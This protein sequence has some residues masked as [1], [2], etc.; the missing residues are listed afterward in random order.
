MDF[1]RILLLWVTNSDQRVWGHRRRNRNTINISLGFC[2][3][4]WLTRVEISP[5]RRECGND[6]ISSRHKALA[7]PDLRHIYTLC[8]IHPLSPA[9]LCDVCSD[10]PVYAET[11]Q[12]C[13][14]SITRPVPSSRDQK[15]DLGSDRRWGVSRSQAP[16]SVAE[17]PIFFAR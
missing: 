3:S 5:R 16:S 8:T 2:Y 15:D 10:V 6:R 9:R 7:I 4:D 12:R 13:S 14:Y 1:R 11:V 17:D